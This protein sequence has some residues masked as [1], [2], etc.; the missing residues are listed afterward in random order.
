MTRNDH[1]NPDLYSLQSSAGSARAE[2]WNMLEE[3]RLRS[4]VPMHRLCESRANQ[5]IAT[6]WPK[7]WER[8]ERTQAAEIQAGPQAT[9]S[10][11]GAQLTSAYDR[12]KEALVQSMRVR[13]SA[14]RAF[15]YGTGLGDLPRVLLARPMIKKLAVVVM[16]TAIFK[17]V[18]AHED[19]SDWLSDERVF[20]EHAEVFEQCY[21]PFAFSPTDVR[22]A[23][24]D[25]INLRD[26]I[27]MAVGA[28]IGRI[29]LAALHD[30]QEA[31][32]AINHG[33]GEPTVDKHYKTRNQPAVVVAA[34]PSVDDQIEW[35]KSVAD[36]HTIVTITRPLRALMYHGIVPHYVI[37][38]DT[39][40]TMIEHIRDLDTSRSTLV[41]DVA[42]SPAFVDAWKG[43]RV[44]FN[45]GKHD[46]LY[47]GGTVTHS[48]M[49][50]AV[51]LG[52]KDI[53][54][55]GFDCCIG[56]RS[57]MHGT[58]ESRDYDGR[59]WTINGHGE[60][61]RTAD[62]MCMF[63]RC[64]ENYIKAAAENGAKFYKR[65]RAGVPFVGA[66]WRD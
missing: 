24:D 7:L 18:M 44:V 25:A 16:N 33:R 20:L 53:T 41:Y 35:L 34:G 19:Q 17:A 36:S 49:D 66:E 15:V 14:D 56:E 2:H 57:H 1:H 43:P 22:I 21:G 30:E 31:N 63:R 23:D 32:R 59:V 61:V 29:Q 58:P 6:R 51:G 54:I 27:T 39:D 60:R 11:D 10:V 4:D 65:G 52:S 46:C 28:D 37:I 45:S 40:K 62:N 50:L 55:I 42:V 38:L 8:I 13:M 47:Q 12:T 64:A 48:A 3:N 9:Y 5:I 26:R